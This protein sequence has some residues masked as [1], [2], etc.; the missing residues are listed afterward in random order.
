MSKFV[1]WFTMRSM[2]REELQRGMK[3][4]Y[5]LQRG[6]MLTLIALACVT[7][8]ASFF[9]KD[10]MGMDPKFAAGVLLSMPSLALGLL[11]RKPGIIAAQ[12]IEMARYVG[13][14]LFLCVF[15]HWMGW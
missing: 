5:A 14:A 6:F 8:V 10:H 1:D 15:F 2:S 7:A 4:D 9:V 13:G 11:G 12:L 3:K